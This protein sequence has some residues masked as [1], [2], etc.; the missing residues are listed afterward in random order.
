MTLWKL[1]AETCATVAQLSDSLPALVV[2]R[3]A[4]MGVTP[5]RKIEC[6]RRG[7]MGGSIVL[8]LGGSVFAIERALAEKIE[9]AD[10]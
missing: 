10:Y 9:L 2:A 7:P 5:G 6:L 1:P 8:Q 3:L 4:E